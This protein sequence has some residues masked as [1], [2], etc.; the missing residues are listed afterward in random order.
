M[1]HVEKGETMSK[2]FIQLPSKDDLG[3]IEL[4]RSVFSTIATNVLDEMDNVQLFEGSK[5]FKGG[6][7]TKVEDN[8]LYLNVP[9]KIQ[10]NA[11]VTD[12]CASL[13]NQIFESI[14]YMTDYKPESIEIQ[15]VGFIF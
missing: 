1:E 12:V 7:A 2:E 3:A 6:I 10:Y 8:K 9:V 13:Q 4:N 15:V 5:P 14:S 11:N